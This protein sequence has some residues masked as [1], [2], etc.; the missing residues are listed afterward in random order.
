M[1]VCSPDPPGVSFA[2]HDQSGTTLEGIGRSEPCAIHAPPNPDART[3]PR[4]PQ[5]DQ[6][7]CHIANEG[8]TIASFANELGR[9][10][11]CMEFHAMGPRIAEGSAGT[12]DG[13]QVS[14]VTATGFGNHRVADQWDLDQALWKCQAF[15]QSYTTSWAQA[16]SPEL[17]DEL[18][19]V[20]SGDR[21]P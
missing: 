4:A 20:Y 13:G 14:G 18:G 8:A 21:T 1:Y 15:R 6:R 17:Y 2:S 3:H 11:G 7:I 16:F 12:P 9:L 19:T 5:P 10:A